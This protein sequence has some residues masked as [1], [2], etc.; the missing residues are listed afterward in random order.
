MWL[1]ARDSNVSVTE[2][3]FKLA[4]LTPATAS[5]GNPCIAGKTNLHGVLCSHLL[6]YSAI[7]WKF[8]VFLQTLRHREAVTQCAVICNWGLS[9]L[10][11]DGCVRAHTCCFIKR[12]AH[13]HRLPRF[14]SGEALWGERWLLLPR[15][16]Q[17]PPYPEPAHT[18]HLQLHAGCSR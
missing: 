17:L 6:L 18:A 14:W 7:L 13:T 2:K 3:T 16:P 1:W 11:Y 12:G 10:F 4:L 5:S 15:W 8:N 9:A